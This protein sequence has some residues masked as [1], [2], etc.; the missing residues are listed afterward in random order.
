MDALAKLSA[1]TYALAEAKTLDDVKRIIDIAEAART[2]ARAAKLGLEAA[3]HAA[4][5]K[6]RAER[7]AGELLTQLAEQSKPNPN[8]LNQHT[9][10]RFHA[11][12][13]PATPYSAALTDSDITRT[14]AHR[15]QTVAQV[16]EEVFEE[17]VAEVKQ[18][19]RELTSAGLLRL[20]GE[21]KQAAETIA[22]AAKLGL[23]AANHAAEVKLR[24]ERKAGELL[25]QLERAPGARTDMQPADSLSAGSEYR[26]AL[27]DS[28]VNERTARRWQTVAQVPDVDPTKGYLCRAIVVA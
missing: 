16:P 10:V 1:A 18:E 12:I 23:E 25:Q 5:V 14:T 8:G 6:L 4:E 19:Q 2:Y 11:G 27:D 7:K 22:R 3:N 28:E 17:H 13:E 20:A 21:I 24:A 26:Q 9:E 15:W